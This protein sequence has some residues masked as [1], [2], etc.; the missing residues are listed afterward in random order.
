MQALC[1]THQFFAAMP[2]A[3][4]YNEIVGSRSRTTKGDDMK[5][6]TN[7]KAGKKKPG[8]CKKC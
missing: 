7:I 8:N 4:L 3:S 6:Q 2:A 1:R 5:V